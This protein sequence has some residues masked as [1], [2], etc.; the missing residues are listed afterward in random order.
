[1]EITER[2]CQSIVT[3]KR[4][5]IVE[6]HLTSWVNSLKLIS[7]NNTPSKNVAL[8]PHL[9][10]ARLNSQRWRQNETRVCVLIAFHQ[11]KN[12]Y[13]TFK[14]IE[15]GIQMK[16]F[17]AYWKM[18]FRVEYKFANTLSFFQFNKRNDMKI[19]YHGRDKT[20]NKINALIQIRI[21]TL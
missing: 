6:I 2:I 13:P 5:V 1:M 3:G 11:S 19:A 18:K 17:F 16:F 15:K 12:I 10:M 14:H 20:W 21:I 8:Q 9:K 4:Y 7:C